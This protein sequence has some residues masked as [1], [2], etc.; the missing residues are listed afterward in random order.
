MDIDVMKAI[1]VIE[2]HGFGGV[3]EDTLNRF[4]L[5]IQKELEQRAMENY[6][7][8][9]YSI[10]LDHSVWGEESLQL[11]LSSGLER[12]RDNKIWAKKAIKFLTP[13][14]KKAFLNIGD[15]ASLLTWSQRAGIVVDG[16]RS[17]DT[18]SHRWLEKSFVELKNLIQK[19]EESVRICQ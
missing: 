6:S 3:N 4:S 7:A 1:R 11:W 15:I 8:D 18:L 5:S 19:E 14:G 2:R 16:L 13:G 12:H 10:L 9:T 17:L